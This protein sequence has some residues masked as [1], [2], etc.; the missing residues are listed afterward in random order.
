MDAIAAIAYDAESPFAIRPVQLD[1]PRDDEVIVRIHGCGICHTDLVIKSGMSDFPFPGVLGHEGAGVV[2]KTGSAVDDVAPGDHVVI[3]FLSCGS[4]HACENDEP[5]YCQHM[6]E[7]NYA[8]A[9]PDGSATLHD[10]GEPLGSMLFAQSS[11]ATYALTRARNLVKVPKHL[12]LELLGPLGCG[13]QTGAGAV[14]RSL[15]LEAGATL[16][17]AGAGSV[18]LSAVMAAQLAGCGRIAVI[19]PMPQRRQLA[20]E[21]GATEAL[22]PADENLTQALAALEPNGFDAALD[23]SGNPAALE[24]CLASLGTRGVL[25]LLGAAQPETALPGT[26]NSVLSR[27]QSV[28]GII[29]G[30]S[31]PR[32]FIPELIAHYEAGR[33]PFDRL[34]RI[35]PFAEINRAVADHER[36]E[37]VKA[38]LT[39][40]PD[41][42]D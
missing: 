9:R 11:F 1:E 23:T 19:E 7:L 13:I 35:Y 42:A 33:F 31:N 40:L 29:E 18:G 5:A 15:A 38:V 26:V 21:L 8:G 24:C 4:C 34:I 16:V 30:D 39:M 27:G 22:D 32:Q 36:G 25:G 12:P 3:S 41:A 20:L 17:V 6:M 28:R 14:L 37:C 2:E 10:Q